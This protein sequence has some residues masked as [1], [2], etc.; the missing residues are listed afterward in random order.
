MKRCTS[1][2]ISSAEKLMYI[3][4]NQLGIEKEY[5]QK[6]LPDGRLS[7]DG[8]ICVF[9]VSI[10]P[11]RSIEKQVDF[12]GAI[13]NNILKTKKPVVVVTTKN[14]ESNDLY[15]REVHKLVQRNEYKGN[16]P[17]IETSAHENVNIDLGFLLL[18]QI[19]DK[20]KVRR[21]ARQ[22]WLKKRSWMPLAR[23]S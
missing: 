1:T 13:L 15:I 3:C 8:F 22:Q 11:S 7:I 21:T 19:I 14:D 20:T 18:A 5:E 9:D 2:K 12:C 10:V 17:L 4:K 6:V 23:H 16:I